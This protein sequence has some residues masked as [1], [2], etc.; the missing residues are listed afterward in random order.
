MVY[1]PAREGF[2]SLDVV[3]SRHIEFPDRL[4]ECLQGKVFCY[5]DDTFTTRQFDQRGG[6]SEC[7]SFS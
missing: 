6:Y 5:G 1:E 7:R 3:S 4:L 2:M